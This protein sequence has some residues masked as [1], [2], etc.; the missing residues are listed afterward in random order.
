[1]KSYLLVFDDGNGAEFQISKFI[2]SLDDGASGITLD[3][4]VCFFKSSLS[5]DEIESILLSL[6]GSRLFF[7]TEIGESP[8][9]GRMLGAHWDL[10]KQRAKLSSA[11]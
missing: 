8:F 10:I 9:V 7:V 2:D 11:A 3:G 6:V 1:M 4:H 5:M